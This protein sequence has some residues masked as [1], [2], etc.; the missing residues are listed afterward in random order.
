MDQNEG[1]NSTSNETDTNTDDSAST[2]GFG[3]VPVG[4]TNPPPKCRAPAICPSIDLKD[5]PEESGLSK[6]L[7]VS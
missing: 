5:P 1:G 2:T 6:P 4:H 7:Q 3:F